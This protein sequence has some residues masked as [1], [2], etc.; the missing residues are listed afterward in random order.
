MCIHI[1]TIL[2]LNIWNIYKLQILVGIFDFARYILFH[3]KTY[4]ILIKLRNLRVE[5]EMQD[6]QNWAV[7]YS[8]N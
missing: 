4:V 6:L 5:M 8:K 7:I 2:K 1:Y 3:L